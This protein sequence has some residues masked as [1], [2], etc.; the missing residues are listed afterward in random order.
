MHVSAVT[1]FTRQNANGMNKNEKTKRHSKHEV[2]KLEKLGKKKK[3]S[4]Q[5]KSNGKFPNQLIRFGNQIS[6]R[7]TQ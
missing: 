1:V 4:N 3:K 7:Q 2:P 6:Y 5:I